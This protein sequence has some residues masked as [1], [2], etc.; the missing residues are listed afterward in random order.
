VIA[1]PL[2]GQVA[3][4]LRQRLRASPSA[5][6]TDVGTYAP[7]GPVGILVAPFGGRG[8]GFLLAGTVTSDTLQRAATELLARG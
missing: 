1:L 8:G 5:Q 6:E 4:P 2:R 3:G 7:V